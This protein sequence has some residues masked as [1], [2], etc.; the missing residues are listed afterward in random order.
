MTDSA[1]DPDENTDVQPFS[2]TGE[3]IYDGTGKS[4]P[5]WWPSR[6]GAD[7]ELGTGN[8]LTPERTL[9][10]LQ[11]VKEG[12]ILELA[13]V[14]DFRSPTW[15]PPGKEG[16]RWYRQVVAAHGQMDSMTL[17]PKN[18]FNYMEEHVSQIYHIGTHMDGFGHIGIGGRYYNGVHY[19]DFYAPAG[20][21][22][23][24]IH[25]V[26]PWVTRG[27]LLN[28]AAVEG[29]EML[30]EGFNITPEHLERACELQNVEVG[31]GDAV[32]LHTGYGALWMVDNDR[33][34]NNE[35]G[36]GWDGAHWLTD[37]RVSLVGTDTWAVEVLPSEVDGAP[38]LVHQHM[39]A[40]TG[41]HLVENMKTE[42]LVETGRSEFLFIMSPVKTRGST[43][44]MVNPLVV[45]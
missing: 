32:I 6:Y 18:D 10:A 36:I 44:S 40:E 25:N 16:A 38:F 45:L 15:S 20:L 19:K 34:N 8:E 33:Y 39:L 4:S 37:R 13:R 22:K 26:K 27:V 11:L 17:G 1:A 9:A 42:E 7:D 24:G 31:H 21:N 2:N 30:T 29:V 41:T 5:Q 28:I 12:R 35:P 43:S 14:L 23:F 3:S